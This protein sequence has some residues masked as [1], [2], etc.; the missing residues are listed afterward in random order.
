MTSWS[1][2]PYVDEHSTV[3]AAGACD[4]WESLLATLDRS[5]SGAAAAA[6]ARAVRCDPAS[7]SGPRPLAEGS[8]MPGFRVAAAVPERELVLVGSHHFS[9]YALVFRLE[10]VDDGIRVVAETRAAFPGAGGRLYRLLVIGSGGHAIGVRR[11]LRSVRRE[12]E[13][14][15]GG[16]VQP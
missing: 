14:R 8:T 7:A 13:Q 6:Y 3:V 10:Q 9:S 11:L 5:F 12:S 1:S 2:L 4:V 16:N 15:S